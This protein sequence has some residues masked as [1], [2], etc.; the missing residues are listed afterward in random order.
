MI[1]PLPFS[2]RLLWV[3]AAICL[4]ASFTLAL[5]LPPSLPLAELIA[6]MD[7]GALVRLQEFVRA[8]FSDWAWTGLVLP[9]L[10]RPDWLVPLAL[11]IVLA[12]M[13][14]SLGSR[15]GQTRADRTRGL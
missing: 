11:G 2:A 4:V 1:A 10:T 7:H 8:H 3:L 9:L 15:S 6:R 5:L 14:V 12:G 13:A